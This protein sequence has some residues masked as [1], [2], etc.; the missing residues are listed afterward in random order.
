ME[1]KQA[2]AV[3]LQMTPEAISAM[4]AAM[5]IGDADF[6]AAFDK[7]P[8]AAIAKIS[9]QEMAADAE[10]VVHRNEEKCWHITLP[11]QEAMSLM[12]DR[13]I[14]GVSG[15]TGSSSDPLGILSTF[16]RLL[17]GV[18]F[19]N[20]QSE[21]STLTAEQADATVNALNTLTDAYAGLFG[22]VASIAASGGGSGGT[23]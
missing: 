3:T 11:S 12:S 17:G 23:P 15:G 9:G 14:S 4:L 20:V 7:D 1:Q 18:V 10:V 16:S 19:D 8:K 6:R 21:R 2:N 13:E 5:Y 22:A